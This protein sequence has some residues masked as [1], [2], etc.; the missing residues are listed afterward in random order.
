MLSELSKSNNTGKTYS[1]KY[2]YSGSGWGTPIYDIVLEEQTNNNEEGKLF[3][4]DSVNV[5][6]PNSLLGYISGLE[7]DY[8]ENAEGNLTLKI[9]Y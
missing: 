7:V 1:I 4:I 9:I 5:I 8:T 6:V 3:T 2:S